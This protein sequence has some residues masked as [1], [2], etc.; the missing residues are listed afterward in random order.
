MSTHDLDLDVYKNTYMPLHEILVFIADHVRG[1]AHNAM[2]SEPLHFAH[3]Q[4]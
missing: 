3:I 1:K 2:F 4:Q